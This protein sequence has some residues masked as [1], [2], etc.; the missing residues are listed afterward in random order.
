[1]TREEAKLA[2]KVY[3]ERAAVIDGER[4][5]LICVSEAGCTLEDKR[6]REFF[7]FWDE[8]TS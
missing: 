8:V 1:M 5:P 6:G 4:F 7:A 3:Q 2:Q